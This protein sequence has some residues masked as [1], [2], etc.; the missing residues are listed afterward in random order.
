M[1]TAAALPTDRIH[2]TVKELLISKRR[3]PAE[4]RL[5]NLCLFRDD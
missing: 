1:T 2:T 4:R 3:C 5:F